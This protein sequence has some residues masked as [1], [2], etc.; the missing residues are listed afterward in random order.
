MDRAGLALQERSDGIAGAADA[1]LGRIDAVGTAMRARGEDVAATGDAAR[2]DIGAVLETLDGATSRLTAAADEA[3]GRVLAVDGVLGDQ[4]QRLTAAIGHAARL[5]AEASETLRAR[6][7]DVEAHAA[8][9]ATRLDAASL[10]HRDGMRA[11][12]EAAQTALAELSDLCRALEAQSARLDAATGRVA[13]VGAEAASNGEALAR[14]T[15]ETAM[16]VAGLGA[17]LAEQAALLEDASSRGERVLAAAAE[18]LRDH[19]AALTA[20]ADVARRAADD[21]AASDI[22][23]RR[24]GFLKSSRAVVDGLNALAIDL[25]RSLSSTLPERL[26]SAYVAGDRGVFVRRVLKV[27]LGGDGALVRAKY[28]DDPAFRGHVDAYVRQFEAL[29]AAAMAADP[30]AILTA[31]FLTSDIGKLYM[32]LAEAAERPDG[33]GLPG[34][35]A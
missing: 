19:G 20:A 14:A 34:G 7:E 15:E 2:R 16:R 22:D 30:D 13:D 8:D 12:A 35:A 25:S 26:M 4:A 27:D 5:A 23:R 29:R 6:A 24:G 28:R 3:Q 1:A 18:R 17:R 9:A 33:A 11:T 31:A 32:F 10:A 21:L